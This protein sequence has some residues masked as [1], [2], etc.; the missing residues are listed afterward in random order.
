M[1]GSTSA[2]SASVGSAA[3]VSS[4]Y[5]NSSSTGWVEIARLSMVN[6]TPG[7]T[8]MIACFSP[9]CRMVPKMPETVMMRAPGSSAAIFAF[10][11]LVRFCC[12]LI[13]RK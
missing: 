10:C 11:S 5:S 2:G 12:G 1:L 9:R 7:A 13:I 4:T 6:S 8:S 3:S